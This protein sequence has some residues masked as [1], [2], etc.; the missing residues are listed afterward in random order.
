MT[1]S[2]P[3]IK[4]LTSNYFRRLLQVEEE[5]ETTRESLSHVLR[6]WQADGLADVLSIKRRTVVETL[7]NLEITYFIRLFAE[8]EGIL[9][10]HLATNHFAVTVPDKPK[11]D[12]LIALVVKADG[13]AVDPALRSKI[14]AVRD[15]RNTLAHTGS[16]TVSRVSFA[17][18]RSYLNT[19][20]AK[21][22][23]P[24]A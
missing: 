17:N 13:F 15:Y 19:F 5:L 23:A 14:N 12:Q 21:L 2:P 7:R 8:F 20:V 16:A 11:V 9:K 6:R 22:S 3:E 10:D 4:R 24:Q 18:A 1:C